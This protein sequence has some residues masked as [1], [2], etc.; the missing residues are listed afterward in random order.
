VPLIVSSSRCPFRARAAALLLAGTLTLILQQVQLVGIVA[1]AQTLVILTAGIDLSV[2]AIAV[3][4]SVVMGQFAFRY[5]IPLG[6]PT[7]S[8]SLRPPLRG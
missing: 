1:A 7:S 4:S 2:G 6:I 8:R 3:L 5:F